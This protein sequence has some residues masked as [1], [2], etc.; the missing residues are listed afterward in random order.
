MTVNFR[1]SLPGNP[2][3]RNMPV[4]FTGGVNLPLNFPA[5]ESWL[6]VKWMMENAIE[7]L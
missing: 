6:D 7:R 1:T 3:L 5:R 2:G 4:K